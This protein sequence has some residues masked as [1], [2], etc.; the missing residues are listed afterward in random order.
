MKTHRGVPVHMLAAG[1]ALVT[2]GCTNPT[3]QPAATEPNAASSSIPPGLSAPFAYGVASG[4]MTSDSAVLWTRTPGPA[5]VTPELSL[6]PSF[7]HPRTLPA[8]IASE[9]SDFTVKVLATELQAGT[10]YFFRFRAGGDI[11][12]VGSFRSAYAPDQH[13][14][15]RMVF[16]GDADWKWKPYPILASL[17]QE[18]ADFFLFLGDLI[19]ESTDYEAKS[20]VEDLRGYRFKYRENREPRANSASRMVPMRDLYAAFGQYSVFDN[21]ETGMSMANRD[22][23]RYTEGGARFKGGYVNHT[24]GF[25]ARIRAYREYQPVREEVHADTGDSRTDETGRFYRAVGWGANVEMIVLD[26][27]SYRDVRLP[28]SDDPAATSCTRTMLGPVQLKWLEDAL[29]AAKRRNAVWKVV[30]ISSPIQEFGVAS[31]VGVEMDGF[32][33]WAG[34]YRCER[35]KILKFID[36]HAIDNVVFLT[37]DNH[38]TAIN[39]LAYETVPDDRRSARRPARNAFEIMTGPLGAV[40]G[41]PP[42]G[43]KFDIKGLPRREADRRILSVWNGESVD[44]QGQLMGLRQASLD[45]IGLEAN[46]PGLEAFSIRS[47][48]GR[49]GVVEPLAFASFNS[50]S[51][52]VLTFDQSHLHVL[53]KTMPAV[54]DPST[55]LKTDA[56]REYESRRAEET[57]SFTVRAQ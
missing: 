9:A 30:V 36:D 56:E 2:I 19:Y 54:A 21:H 47:A 34:T 26:D 32:K 57:F 39:N 31:Q 35:N 42:Y 38:Y 41:T 15:V 12:P 6:T 3:L 5:S 45:P 48:G 44:D 17:V 18:N 22:G 51:Y 14:A 53:V 27:R 16:T 13:A 46:F 11:S 23:P 20:V 4:D 33:S 55:L 50:Y 25:R 29:H 40:T 24:E 8:A 49:P 1:I 7:D 43:R 10:R 37:T 28:S 52:A